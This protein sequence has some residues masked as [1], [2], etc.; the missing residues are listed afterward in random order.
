MMCILLEKNQFDYGESSG[1]NVHRRVY[2]TT[3]LC[4]F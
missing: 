3:L 4:H 2:Q 1:V